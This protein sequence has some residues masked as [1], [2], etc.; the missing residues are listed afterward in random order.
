MISTAELASLRAQAEASFSATAT[1]L[2]KS[3]VSDGAGGQTDSYTN[4]GTFPCSYAP[5]LVTPYERE[6]FE[7]ITAQGIWRFVFPAGTTILPTDRLT[8]D[9]RSFEVTYGGQPSIQVDL[10]VWAQEIL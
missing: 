7:R 4:I 9:G 2:R 3:T 1:V 8:V 5:A 6:R 10:I